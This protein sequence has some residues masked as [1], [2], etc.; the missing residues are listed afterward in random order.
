MTNSVVPQISVCI[1]TY[2]G[3]EHL[4]ECIESIR[5]QTFEDFEALICDDQ[6][7]DGTLD[8]ARELAAGDARFRLIKN[9]R[10]F[11]LVGNWNNC[12]RQARGEWIKFVFQDDVV[13]PRCLEML[14][15]ACQSANKTFGFCERDFIF[16]NGTSESS[17]DWFMGHKKRLQRDYGTAASIQAEQ[18]IKIAAQDPS[19]NLVG[20]PTITLIKKSIFTELGGFDEALI[21]FCD[22]EFWSRVMINYGAAFVPESL[23]AF[24][25]HAS[26]TTSLNLEKRLFRMG[27]L[28]TLVLRY[29]FA[30]GRH[31]KPVRNPGITGKSVFSL[32]KECASDAANVWGQARQNN[33]T[34]DGF[35]A[36]EE[37][38]SVASH[39]AGLQTLAWCGR[40]IH[41]Y[42]RIKTNIAK[43]QKAAQ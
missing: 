18:A 34:N 13:M 31:F 38:K 20:E 35:N 11:G 26:A 23:A 9:P 2:N 29:R 15:A 24:R 5:A 30:F 41:L 39:C 36:L 12:I 40:L 37:W 6:S 1:P 10:R 33:K 22:A 19:H 25:I 21:Q 17:R 8:F 42:R 32:R 14:L 28:D 27:T 4:K 43:P 7:A 16:E 3:R